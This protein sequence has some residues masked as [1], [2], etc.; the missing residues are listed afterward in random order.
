[1]SP[2]VPINLESIKKK[3]NSNAIPALQETNST[4]SKGKEEPIEEFPF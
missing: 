2:Q 4:S 3:T 1:V